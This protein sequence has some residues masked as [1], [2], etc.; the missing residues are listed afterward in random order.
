V[1]RYPHAVDPIQPFTAT[2][3]DQIKSDPF[4]LLHQEVTVL[5]GV[6]G[7]R[8]AAEAASLADRLDVS[9]NPDGT[10]K[11]ELLLDDVGG[12][13]GSRRYFCCVHSDSITYGNSGTANLPATLFPEDPLV[14]TGEWNDRT[15]AAVYDARGF[16]LLTDLAPTGVR[17]LLFNDGGTAN[18]GY[19]MT[20]LVFSEPEIFDSQARFVAPPWRSGAVLN[21]P[22]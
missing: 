6:L 20:A 3:G 15:S 1:S 2:D 17:A 12:G 9:M 7:R 11:K 13:A 14:I 16:F 21:A 4:N 10:F 22:P 8:I 18:G 19:Y 5:Q